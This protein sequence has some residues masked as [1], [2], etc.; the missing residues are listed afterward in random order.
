MRIREAFAVR[1]ADGQSGALI[2]AWSCEACGPDFRIA[3]RLLLASYVNRRLRS[4]TH[5][6]LRVS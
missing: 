3:T 4:V 2:Y 5:D 1:P 6:R